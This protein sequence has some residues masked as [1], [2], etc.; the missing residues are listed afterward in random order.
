MPWWGWLLVL[1][2]LGA[3][4]MLILMFGSAMSRREEREWDNR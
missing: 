2:G 4:P 1:F 3:V